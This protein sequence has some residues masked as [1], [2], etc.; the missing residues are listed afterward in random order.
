MMPT[1]N[2]APKRVPAGYR[3]GVARVCDVVLPAFLSKSTPETLA[4]VGEL[5][6]LTEVGLLVCAGEVSIKIPVS[7]TSASFGSAS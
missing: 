1:A 3:L 2:F 5:E 7:A 6:G 4:S